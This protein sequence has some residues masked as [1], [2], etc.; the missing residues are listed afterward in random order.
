MAD[1]NKVYDLCV[2]GGG[3]AG[4]GVARDAALRGLSVVL[5]EKGAFASGAS[6]K[7]SK[8]IHGGIRYLETAAKA[9]G[10]GRLREAWKNF[11]FVFASLREART[12]ETI[13][14]ALVR[15]VEILIPVYRGS[16]RG[17]FVVTAGALLYGV[18][19]AL[20]GH[21][22]FPR[23]LMGAAAVRKRLPGLELEGLRGGVLI[24]ERLV[25][26]RKL[27][28][29]TIESAR[30][31]GTEAR[32]RTEVT[33]FAR[34]KEGL[35]EIEAK[36]GLSR[37]S[38]SARALID[39]TGAWVDRTRS[40]GGGTGEPWILPV[41][42]AHIELPRFAPVSALL[43]AEDHRLFFA[44][45][46]GDRVRV[47][48]TERLERDPNAVKAT[49]AEIDYLLKSLRKF[50]PDCGAERSLILASDAGVRPLSRSSE[51]KLGNISREHEV[52]ASADGA[53]HL[54]G[55]KL[56]DHR[57]AAE[58]AVD[59]IVRHLAGTGRSFGPCRTAVTRLGL[60]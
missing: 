16:S 34:S 51:D 10:R 15:P 12:L 19:A 25:D 43:E 11:R 40:L 30:S 18:L 53:L 32:E 39:A 57:R 21:R 4:A 35:F 7:S 59:R 20:S 31:H 42:G 6:S 9:A 23:I 29:A 28:E 3:I 46:I 26:D 33:R 45:N 14:P 8:L 5:L 36:S 17:L 52:R 58:E 22:Y 60:G 27:V 49:D 41:A 1:E 44:V 50:F 24:Q 13:A 47:G 38:Y 2:I 48:T 54:I 37:P 56:T 55:V